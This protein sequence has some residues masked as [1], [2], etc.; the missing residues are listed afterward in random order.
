MQQW[1]GLGLTLVRFKHGS[2]P[3]EPNQFKGAYIYVVGFF[4]SFSMLFL[5]LPFIFS[6]LSLF[7]LFSSPTGDGMVEGATMRRSTVM[8]GGA[9]VVNT[10]NNFRFSAFDF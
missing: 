5:S 9:A 7:I 6:H 10:P 8:G 2:V 1:I 4:H 3:R